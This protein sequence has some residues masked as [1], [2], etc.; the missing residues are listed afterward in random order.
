MFFIVI[1]VISRESF[2]WKPG[3][4]TPSVKKLCQFIKN[5]YYFYTKSIIP[6]FVPWFKPTIATLCDVKSWFKS[7]MGLV[8]QFRQ[9]FWI[10]LC[11]KITFED[12]QKIFGYLK[13]IFVPLW[14]HRI[15]RITRLCKTSFV[16]SY[17]NWYKFEHFPLEGFYAVKRLY[18]K[19]YSFK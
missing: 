19:L 14:R 6:W 12:Q 16:P 3:K 9:V 2:C 11:D 8:Y 17:N 10:Q 18:K 1:E 15:I 5:P 4:K 13:T 7:K